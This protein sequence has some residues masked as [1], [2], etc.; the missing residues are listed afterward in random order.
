MK[1]TL[2]GKHGAGKSTVGKILAEKLG[3]NYFYTGGHMREMAEKRGLNLIELSRLANNDSSIDKKIDD[4]QINIG[5][6]QD[7]FILDAHLAFHFIPD[8]IKIFFE[9]D[10]NEGAKRILNEK[11]TLHRK[12]EANFSDINSVI[13]NLKERKASEQKRW[14]EMYGLNQDDHTNYDFIINTTNISAE[15]VANKIIEFIKSKN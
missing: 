8:S 11:N 3:Y 2:A 14:K 15:E 9:V 5:K 1:I 7:N 10:E 13:S 4:W 12:K 6:T